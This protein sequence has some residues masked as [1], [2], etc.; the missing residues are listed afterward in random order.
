MNDQESYFK[1]FTKINSQDLNFYHNID[2][3]KSTLNNVMFMDLQTWIQN[4]SLARNDKLYMDSGIEVRVPFLDNEMIEK[5][6]F[7]SE[8]KKINFFK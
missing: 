1:K 4:D 2:N 7:M 8:H 5:F 3:K 6:L